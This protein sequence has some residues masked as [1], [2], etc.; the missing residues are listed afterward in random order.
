MISKDRLNE[1]IELLRACIIIAFPMGLPPETAIAT[2]LDNRED[3]SQVKVK[4]SL[5][6]N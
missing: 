4:V 1:L 6:G 2:I 3:L 5:P